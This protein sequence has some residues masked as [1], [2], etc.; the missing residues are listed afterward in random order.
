MNRRTIT[1]LALAFIVGAILFYL[2]GGSTAPQGQQP[3]LRLNAENLA[4]LKDAFNGSAS[5]VRVLV[6]VSPT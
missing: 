5:S 4:S 6:L 3:L 2:Y 1:L